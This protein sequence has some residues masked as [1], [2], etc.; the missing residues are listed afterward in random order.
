MS[1]PTAQSPSQ[2]R[3]LPYLRPAGTG[4][5]L[6]VDGAPRLL[7]GGQTHNSSPSSADYMTGVFQHLAAMNLNTVIVSASWGQ[8]EP[9]EGKYDFSLVDELIAQAKDHDLRLILIWFGAFKN[10]GSTYAPSW[11]RA[12][13]ERFPRAVVHKKKQ[14]AFS[15]VGE[16]PKPVLSVCSAELR[17]VEQRTFA[18]LLRHLQIADPDHVVVMVQVENETGVLGDSRDR[19]A[20]AQAA[21][22]SPVPAQLLEHLERRGD[23]L[24]PELA[25]LWGRHGRRQAG[26]WAEVFGDDWEAEE[27]FMAW[28][29]ASHAEALASVGK[30]EK[31]LPMFVN[32]WLGPQPGQPHAGDYPSGGPASRVLDVWKAAAPSLDFLSPDIYTEDVKAALADYARDDNPLFIPEAQFRT[33]SVF[34]A[35]GHHQALGFSVFGVEDGRTDG[36]LAGAYALLGSM[37]DVILAAQAEG[38]IEGILLDADEPQ[39]ALELG[40]YQVVVQSSRGLIGKMLLDAGVPS[41]PP[42]P[43][44]PSETDAPN[45]PP[46]PGDG[47][48]FGLLVADGPDEFLLVGRGLTVDFSHSSGIVEIDWAVEGR[49]ENGSW[50]PGRELNGDE[51]LFLV[52]PDDFGAVRIRLLITSS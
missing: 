33:G 23:G 31:A 51:R 34:F 42:Q 18:A 9:V 25:A 35:L 14:A 15:Y 22:E 32:A 12:D 10:A 7:L 46:M 8:V 11:V 37:Q 5:Q 52:P 41:L 20:G 47:R 27:V 49:Y 4:K 44:L 29:I 39:V 50:R 19:S 16:M 2:S 26:T 13:I 40:G 24:R 21:W 48:A 1:T 6:I 28:S 45:V 3:P 30:A 17:D 43:P 36:Q 38:R